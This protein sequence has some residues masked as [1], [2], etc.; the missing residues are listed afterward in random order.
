MKLQQALVVAT[1]SLTV[2]AGDTYAQD[3]PAFGRGRI[4]KKMRDDIL[5]VMP[6]F[7]APSSKSNPTTASRSS[8]S[9]PSKSNVPT[10]ALPSEGARPATVDSKAIHSYRVPQANQKKSSLANGSGS[11]QYETYKTANPS[12]TVRPSNSKSTAAMSTITPEAIASVTQSAKKQSLAFG[13][14]LKTR[15]DDLVVT[16]VNPNGNASKA[17]VRKGDLILGAG[18][19]EFGSMMEFNQITDVLRD[20][21][22]LEF[23]VGQAGKESKKLI[24]F[25]KIPDMTPREI[26]HSSSPGITTSSNPQTATPRSASTLNQY[27]LVSPNTTM[28]SVINSGVDQVSPAQT[29]KASDTW[30]YTSGRRKVDQ[31]KALE[32]AAARGETILNVP[33]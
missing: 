22:Q 33:N 21:D 9:I 2:F 3:G 10:P 14:L 18:G 23:L 28:H 13:M 25:G 7:R 27:E 1:L 31:V 5:G 32:A 8:F 29:S 19:I 6:K 20:G 30:K 4:L 26:A 11:T 12:K 16:Q 17:G 15:G 24:A